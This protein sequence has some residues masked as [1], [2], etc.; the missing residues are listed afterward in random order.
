MAFSKKLSALVLFNLAICLTLSAQ[1]H[2]VQLFIEVC[3]WCEAMGNFYSCS[4]I[5][6]GFNKW[7][8]SRLTKTWKIKHSHKLLH[9]HVHMVISEE[10]NY[11]NYRTRLAD[12]L[13][14]E[15]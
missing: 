14:N 3:K 9:A 15:R 6:G 7:C 11:S 13:R 4:G 5:F 12:K 10:K 8:T 2:V 1:T